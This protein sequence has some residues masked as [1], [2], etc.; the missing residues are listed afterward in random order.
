MKDCR[1]WKGSNNIGDVEMS[2]ELFG[3]K[4]VIENGKLVGSESLVLT[5]EEVED[6][7]SD[8]RDLIWWNAWRDVDHGKGWRPLSQK[9]F[10]ELIGIQLEML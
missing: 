10:N 8:E 6:M 5:V 7:P 2:I 4:P 3:N 1:G 9:L